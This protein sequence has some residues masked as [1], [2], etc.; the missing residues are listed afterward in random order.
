M[1]SKEYRR[2]LFKKKTFISGVYPNVAK[3][4]FLPEDDKLDPKKKKQ[5]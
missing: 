4:S 5:D 3:I 1:G 2:L